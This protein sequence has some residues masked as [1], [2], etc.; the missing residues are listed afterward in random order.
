MDTNKVTKNCTRCKI[1]KELGEFQNDK[2][3]RFGKRNICRDCY[4][5]DYRERRIRNKESHLNKDRA[6]Y[7]RNKDKIVA[8]RREYLVNNKDR[9][10]ARSAVSAAVRHGE[11]IRPKICNRCKAESS[12]IDAHHEDYSKPLLVEW[13][14]RKCHQ[15]E[16]LQVLN[17]A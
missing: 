10:A 16:H 4:R 3:Q 2:R 8:K 7:I 9:V 5:L 17:P 13:L 1:D 12:L 6:Y 11:L 15:I 14:C